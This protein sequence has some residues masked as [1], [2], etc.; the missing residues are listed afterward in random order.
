MDEFALAFNNADVL[1]VLDIYAASETPIEG[2]T[3]EVLTENIRRYGHKNATYLGELEGAA[4]RVHQDLLPGNLVIT[5]GAGSI[6]RLSEEI[7]ETSIQKKFI[8]RAFDLWRRKE[9]SVPLRQNQAFE[10][11]ERRYGK[12][13]LGKLELKVSLAFFFRLY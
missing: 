10:N 8:L 6:T 1:Y 12:L 11:D 5:L 3:A 13:N 2:I 9:I 7:V 4:E